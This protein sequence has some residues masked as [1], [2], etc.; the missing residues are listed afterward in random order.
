MFPEKYIIFAW[1]DYYPAGALGDMKE[2]YPTLEEAV[3]EASKKT[4]DNWCIVN[5]DTMEEVATGP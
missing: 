1:D 2:S 4:F 5:R 3:S